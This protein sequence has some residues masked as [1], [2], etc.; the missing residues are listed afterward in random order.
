MFTLKIKQC[1]VLF[2]LTTKH[3]LFGYGIFKCR[4]INKGRVMLNVCRESRV[5]NGR[6]FTD[7]IK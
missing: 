1:L 2:L 5:N 6:Q 3:L 4:S 7:F